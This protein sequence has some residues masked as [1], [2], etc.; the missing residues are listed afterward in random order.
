MS[1]EA[2][3]KNYSAAANF[4]SSYWYH[5]Q[6][7]NAAPMAIVSAAS[8]KDRPILTKCHIRAH[9]GGGH[10]SFGQCPKFCSFFYGFP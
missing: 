2:I 6:S 8:D 4:L 3:K 9:C 5:F 7:A 1:R 10:Q